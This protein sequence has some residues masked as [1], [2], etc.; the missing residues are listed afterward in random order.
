MRNI[1]MVL[2]AIALLG[3]MSSC[4]ADH[5]KS[6]PVANCPV[7]G[8][9]KFEAWLDAMPGPGSTGPTLN[10]AGKVDL[11][12]PGYKLELIA[13]PADRAMPPSQRFRLVATAPGG[14]VAQVVT[15][16]EVKYRAHAQ[17]PAYRSLVIL[18]GDRSVATISDIPTVH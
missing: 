5:P 10:L 2:P 7:I 18:C 16:T 4:V 8:E 11:P 13:G 15:T 17:Y 1:V 6:Q 12:T 9:G 3:G 14:M